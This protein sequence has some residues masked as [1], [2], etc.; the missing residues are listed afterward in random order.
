MSHRR[1]IGFVIDG[2]RVKVG[3]QYSGSGFYFFKL[4]GLD[5]AY[6]YINAAVVYLVVAVTAS[7]SLSVKLQ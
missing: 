6:Y 2:P 7:E 3:F 1:L 5:E 4:H